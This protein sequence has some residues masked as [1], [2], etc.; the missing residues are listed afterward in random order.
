M[1]LP[2]GCLDG[3]LEVLDSAGFAADVADSRSDGTPIT[4]QLTAKLR[5]AQRTAVAAL[6]A[7][8][9]GVLVAP[10][11][12]GKTVI[13]AALIALRAQSTLV[14]VHRRPLLEQWVTRLTEVLDLDRADIGT[15]IDKPGA[16]GIDVVMI[17]SV[18]R[19]GLDRTGRYGHVV[20]DECHHVPA[21]STERVLRD[22]VSH[23]PALHRQD[24]V[25]ASVAS[26]LPRTLAIQEIL[27]AVARDERRSRRI[28]RDTLTELGERRFPLVLTE[29]REHLLT[30]AKLM[31]NTRIG[32]SYSTAGSAHGHD[33]PPMRSSRLMNRG[34]SSQ[35]A[36]SSARGSTTRAWT[37]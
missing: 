32:L 23:S 28:A 5:P 1:W 30:L 12:A 31:S 15:S 13:A 37:R 29:R 4:A 3:A 8:D 25:M 24:R 35:P 20:V 6:A 9:L 17:Q 27:G 21:F 26:C 11:G 18:A 22:R 14:L 33:A 10:P 2:R 16:S 36:G 19:K 7:H 34:S